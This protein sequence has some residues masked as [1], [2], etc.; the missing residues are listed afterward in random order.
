MKFGPVTIDQAVGAILAHSVPIERGVLKKGR[1]LSEQDVARLAASGITQVIAARLEPDDVGEDAAAHQV[2]R[3]V[4]GDGIRVAEPFTG[5]ANLFAEQAGVAV[6]DVE[7]LQALNRIDEGLTIATLAPFEKVAAGQML[8][9]VKIITFA[10][11][12]DTIKRA[13]AIAQ[14]GLARVAQFSAHRAALILTR[15][16]NT[17]TSV[18]DKRTEVTRERLASVG[19]KLVHTVT[20]PHE[21]GPVRDAILAAAAD[22]C[23][24]ILVFAASA[25]VDRGDVI[26]AAV[27]AAGGNVIHLGMPVDPGNL[28]LT[29][30]LGN[31]DV[32]GAPSCAGSPKLNG[33]DWVLERR[34]AGLPVGA[35]EIASMGVGGLLKEIATRPQPRE[36]RTSPAEDIR[37]EPRI[38][39]ILLAA[40]RSTRMG[41]NNKLLEKVG[42]TMMIRHVADAIVASRARPLV[43]VTGHMANDVSAVLSGFDATIVHN[44]DYAQGLSTSLKA[45]LAALPAGLDGVV[46]ALGDMPGIRAEHIDRMISAFA[47]KESRS[48]I[49]PVYAGKR[50]NPVLWGSEFFAEMRE[51]SGDTGAKHLIGAN[52]EKVVELDLGSDAVLI[53]IDTPEALAKARAER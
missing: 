33:F 42:G 39:C 19:S 34:L 1:A 26:P 49:V 45:G 37:R 46:V 41:A 8:A 15:L 30:R 3:A 9:T 29:A 43:V 7:K 44:P 47:P 17:K 21:T 48:I 20:V 23:D 38:G 52:A 53:D 5:R 51:A 28:L 14:G 31:I 12:A 22:D 16:S 50:G 36:E 2:A 6:L 27:V 13:L 35:D 24:P 4:A 10:V 25:I 40:G 11:G 32:F 18:L